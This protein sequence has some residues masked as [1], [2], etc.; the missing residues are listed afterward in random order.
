MGIGDYRKP[1]SLGT[2]CTRHASWS[3]ISLRPLNVHQ[4]RIDTIGARIVIGM[5]GGGVAGRVGQWKMHR[6][7]SCVCPFHHCCI[8][9]ISR[10]GARAEGIISALPHPQRPPIRMQ[11]DGHDSRAADTVGRRIA[12]DDEIAD[13]KTPMADGE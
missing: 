10:P 3:A 1:D 8:N 12:A 13:G 5:R 11:T 6:K 9:H 7:K 4:E 2:N